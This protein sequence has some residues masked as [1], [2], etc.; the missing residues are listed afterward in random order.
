MDRLEFEVMAC[1]EVMLRRNTSTLILT[2]AQIPI[3]TLTLTQT[4]PYPNL[5]K[6]IFIRRKELLRKIEIRY[7]Y[8]LIYTCVYTYMC[9]YIDLLTY[10][11]TCMHAFATRDE[12]IHKASTEFQKFE[13]ERLEKINIGL[14]RFCEFEKRSF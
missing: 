11:Y 12:M 5:L 1:S 8:M 9:L 2:L 10:I 7:I 13:K 4:P 6:E 14:R 3:L